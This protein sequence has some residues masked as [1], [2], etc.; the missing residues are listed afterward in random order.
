MLQV[1]IFLRQEQASH[2]RGLVLAALLQSTPSAV[3][4]WQPH[5]YQVC[6]HIVLSLRCVPGSSVQVTGMVALFG[7]A[8]FFFFLQS[9][10]SEVA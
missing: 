8:Q 5:T 3:Q 9:D 10:F 2:R 4:A 6:R 7:V 1:W